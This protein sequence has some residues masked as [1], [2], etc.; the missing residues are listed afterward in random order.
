MI[1]KVGLIVALAVIGG[2]IYAIESAKPDITANRAG[3]KSDDSDL[4]VDVERCDDGFCTTTPT[5]V[6]TVSS[7]P[8]TS[9]ATS[10][11]SVA[12]ATKPKPRQ[13]LPPASDISTIDAFIN[14]PAGAG[15]TGGADGGTPFSLKDY[16]GKKIILVDFWTYSCIN[17]QRTTPYL[18][19]WHEKYADKGLLVVGV[20]TPEFEFEK[21]YDNV[22]AAVKKFDIKYP[23]VLDNDYSTWFA[24]KN[25]YWP[26]KYLIDTEGRIA[27][28]HIGEGAYEE[29]EMK[30][31]ELLGELAGTGVPV[32]G[33][34]VARAVESNESMAQSPEVYFGALRNTLAENFSPGIATIFDI[35][36]MPL[37]FDRD[38][39]Y[40][41]GKWKIENEF[42]RAEEAGNRVVFK[43][44]GAKVYMVADAN[45]SGGAGEN[46]GKVK[47]TVKRDG[48][49]VNTVTVDASQLYTLIDDDTP[50]EHTMELYIDGAGL[51]IYTFTFG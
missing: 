32:D 34:L 37:S 17:C 11:K 12:P 23:V 47:V 30:I 27:Y 7:T 13:D 21:D 5:S 38:K 35:E 29:T 1:K 22:L 25:R 19:A 24:Y 41:E 16:V 20:H 15:E 48:A 18:N 28:D 31:Q 42:A 10:A 33:S 14:S 6:A 8:S 45:A 3:D 49:V 4:L 39:L 50:G 44:Y 26:R 2:S 36:K 9:P 51:E 46:G 43:Y 40:I